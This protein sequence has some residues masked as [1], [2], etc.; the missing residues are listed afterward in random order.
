VVRS[1][2]DRKGD[3]LVEDLGEH[4]LSP[5]ENFVVELRDPRGG[6]VGGVPESLMKFLLG[7]RQERAGVG[8]R[9]SEV[10]NE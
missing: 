8:E 3:K 1:K 2:L 10:D 7:D 6:S 5:L 9:F 4:D